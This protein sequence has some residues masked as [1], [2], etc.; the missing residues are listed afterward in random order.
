MRKLAESIK[1]PPELETMV[2][3]IEVPLEQ[4]EEA[5]VRRMLARKRN[6][7]MLEGD[8]LGRTDLI[9]HEIHT[10]A[11]IPLRQ[12]ARR[13]PI[14]QREEG[15]HQVQEMLEKGLIEPSQ[16]PWASPVVLVKK[17]DGSTRFCID[18]RRLNNITIKD[19]YPL[20]RIDDSLDA[21]S[22]ADCFSTLDLASGYWQVGLAPAAKEHLLPRSP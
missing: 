21:L 12:P 18:Y 3:A 17:K 22:G 9:E 11:Q 20:P 8:R 19:A 16:S 13:F 10:T 5:E 4:G 1:L 14:H 15:E 2:K 7:F 6:A